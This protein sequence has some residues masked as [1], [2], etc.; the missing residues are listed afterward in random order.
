MIDIR[1]FV[2]LS[3]ITILFASKEG[4]KF[5]VVYIRRFFPHSVLITHHKQYHASLGNEGKK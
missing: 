1:D 5:D 3:H 4:E 2:D